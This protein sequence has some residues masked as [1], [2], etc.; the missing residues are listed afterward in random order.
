M[1]LV[2]TIPQWITAAVA[3]GALWTAYNSL[4]SQREI[5]R[6]RAAMDFFTKTEMDKNTLD[7]HKEFKKAVTEF[8]KFRGKKDGLDSFAS[9]QDYLRIRDYLN[10]HELMSVGIERNV[11]DDDVCY[12]FWSG[13][14]FRAY[15][16]THDLIQ[17]VQELEGEADTYCELKMVHKRWV[18]REASE[19]RSP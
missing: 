9:T 3:C 13:E 10:L 15:R 4:G 7:Q 5:A 17:Y 2:G 16:D 8:A 6:K 18:L 11:F 12:D 19:A 14:L 1:N